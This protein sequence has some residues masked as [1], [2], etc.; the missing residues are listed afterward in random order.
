MT[1]PKVVLQHLSWRCV[2]CAIHNEQGV[3]KE[4]HPSGHMYMARTS[5]SRVILME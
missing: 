4:L 5:N 1:V 2:E 3:R